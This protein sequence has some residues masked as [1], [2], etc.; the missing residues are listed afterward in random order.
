MSLFSGTKRTSLG[1]VQIGVF[2]ISEALAYSTAARRHNPD[3]QLYASIAEFSPNR[4]E[5]ILSNCAPAH[6]NPPLSATVH[7]APDLI[8]KGLG[9]NGRLVHLKSLDWFADQSYGW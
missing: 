9:E 6:P 4:L 3:C 7:L 2:C 5:K 1:K 8:L